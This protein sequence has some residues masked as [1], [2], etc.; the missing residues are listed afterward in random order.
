[1]NLAS[2]VQGITKY[3]KSR[4]LV[5]EATRERLGPR[6]AARRLG[7][8]RVVNIG[9]PVTLFEIDETGDPKWEALCLQYESA[10]AEF[11][12]QGF[13]M[14]ARILAT[15]TAEHPHDGPSLVLLSRAVNALVDPE[16]F[17]PVFVAPGK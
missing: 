9:E 6:F 10:L 11:E 1:M 16:G 12:R 4:L 3:M 14:A 5:T 17:D 15:I 13:R 2:R 7:Q 8:V